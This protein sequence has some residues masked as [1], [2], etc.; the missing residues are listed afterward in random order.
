MRTN[1][2]LF[3]ILSDNT[4]DI[5]LKAFDVSSAEP[6]MAPRMDFDAHRLFIMKSGRTPKIISVEKSVKKTNQS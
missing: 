6:S 5:I 2:F 1:I 4:P 3:L